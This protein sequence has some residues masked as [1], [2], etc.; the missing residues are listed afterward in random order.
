MHN[1]QNEKKCVGLI[2]DLSIRH[3]SNGKRIIDI[4]KKQMIDIVREL[5]VDG[6]DTFYLY[7]PQIYES[8]ISHAESVCAIGNYNSDGWQFNVNYALRQTLYVMLSEDI[9]FN[10]YIIIVTDRLFDQN[11][12][13]KAIFLNNKENINCHFFLIGIGDFFQKNLFEKVS[14]LKNVT[15]LHLN[16]AADLK[17]DL[18]KEKN[19]ENLYNTTNEQYK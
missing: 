9:T 7:H 4:V 19:G 16:K 6:E 18:F 1:F 17:S 15:L 8:V 13:E 2:F 10:K 14:N 12:M 3:D 5:L 11:I